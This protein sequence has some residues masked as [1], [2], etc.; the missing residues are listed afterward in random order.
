MTR[1]E[2]SYADSM[3]KKLTKRVIGKIA[4]KISGELPSEFAE[5][6][7][8]T[9]SAAA[10]VRTFDDRVAFTETLRRHKEAFASLLQHM[11]DSYKAL[12]ADVGRRATLD[13]YME[14]QLRWRQGL[15]KAHE[16]S[17]QKATEDV[18]VEEDQEHPTF[19][20]VSDDWASLLL[21]HDVLRGKSID[22]LA[23]HSLLIMFQ[24]LGT[25][26]W[27]F[28]QK[29]IMDKKE[30]SAQSKGESQATSSELVPVEED[31]QMLFRV[32]GAQLHSMLELRKNNEDVRSKNEISAMQMIMMR[33]EEQRKSL[34]HTILA[35]ERGGRV[36]P[37]MCLI[38]FLQQINAKLVK[39]LE[40]CSQFGMKMFDELHARLAIADHYPTFVTAIQ[41]EVVVDESFTQDG[42]LFSIYQ[43]LMRKIV[44]SRKKEWMNAKKKL[45][46]LK[47]G[48]STDVTLNLRDELKVYAANKKT[49]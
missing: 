3:S 24:H 31:A 2:D 25:A 44:N 47:E 6:V 30:E 20:V 12:F 46:Q 40:D 37:R 14:L 36:F 34:P 35:V 43:E 19:S 28:M 7:L 39:D 10:Y 48:A 11:A 21:A 17:Y 29:S 49:T 8:E 16:Y 27:D 32:C 9:I 45:Q 41:R 26:V 18:Q 38:P 13:R 42:T 33:K 5:Q 22:E 15:R 4:Q 23:K 1:S